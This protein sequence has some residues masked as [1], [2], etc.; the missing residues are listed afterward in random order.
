MCVPILVHEVYT[1]EE[2]FSEIL[3]VGGR[4]TFVFVLFDGV[5]E[6]VSELFEDEAEM[7]MV[8]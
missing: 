2:L 7:F 1:F 8:V 3:D 6:W 4:E 5:V